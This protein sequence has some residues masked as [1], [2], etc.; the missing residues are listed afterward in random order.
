MKKSAKRA[1]IQDYEIVHIFS[2]MYAGWEMDYEAWIARNKDGRLV[3]LQTN[4]GQL[5]D[6]GTDV[7]DLH[8]KLAEMK[9]CMTGI[10]EAIMLINLDFKADDRLGE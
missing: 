7:S 5:Y 3:L 1:D 8:E 2:M 10:K 9:T 6:H 4:H